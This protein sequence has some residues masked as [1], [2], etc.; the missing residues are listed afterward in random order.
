ME[1][2]CNYGSLFQENTLKQLISRE[3]PLV[4]V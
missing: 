2:T 4:Q 3:F 1:A